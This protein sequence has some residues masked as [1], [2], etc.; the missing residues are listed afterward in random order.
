MEGGVAF[1]IALTHTVIEVVGAARWWT[2]QGLGNL[3]DSSRICIIVRVEKEGVR[4]MWTEG[5]SMWL[6]YYSHTW[7]MKL[8]EGIN[9]SGVQ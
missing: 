6:Q 3:R 4:G 7:L 1:F 5:R 9:S 8:F 2:L